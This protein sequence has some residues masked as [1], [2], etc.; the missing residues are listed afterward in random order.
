MPVPRKGAKRLN[1]RDSYYM[2][3]MQNTKGSNELLVELA[4]AV[5]GQM[6]VVSLGRIVDYAMVTLAID[7]ALANGWKPQELL[8]PFRCIYERKAFRLLEA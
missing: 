7:F 6:L 4:A 2:W 5:N 1:H 3:I 8:P